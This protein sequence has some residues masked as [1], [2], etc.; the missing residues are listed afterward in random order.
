M[1]FTRMFFSPLVLMDKSAIINFIMKMVITMLVSLHL[2][3]L[4]SSPLSPP[5]SLSTLP[6]SP[7][8]SP[9]LSPPLH[10]SHPLHPSTLITYY[11]SPLIS[12]THLLLFFSGEKPFDTIEDLVQD[13]LITLYMEANNVEEYL[14]SARETRLEHTSVAEDRK[15][16]PA[17]S[18]FGNGGTD[19]SSE[20][21]GMSM[22]QTR[23]RKPVYHPC[24][25]PHR[26]DCTN[27]QISSEHEG[28]GGDEGEDVEEQ[29]LSPTTSTSNIVSMGV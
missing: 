10:S 9:F 24:T 20:L 23:A 29:N 22:V 3:S 16:D 6:P 4:H 12:N 18:V 5:L 19:L 11:L 13:G 21:E 2:P 27:I 15:E 25:I 7:P 8:L 28:E 26:R 17:V 14:Q 1:Y